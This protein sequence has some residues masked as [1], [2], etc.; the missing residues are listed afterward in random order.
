MPG[1][2]TELWRRNEADFLRR[3]DVG[4][5]SG[6]EE[7]QVDGWQREETELGRRTKLMA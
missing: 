3:G 2:E 1:E 4:S 7:N 6:R 5:L